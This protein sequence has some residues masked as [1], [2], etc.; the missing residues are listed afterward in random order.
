MFLAFTA[1]SEMVSKTRCGFSHPSWQAMPPQALLPKP[2][3]LLNS[4]VPR[5]RLWG[6][7]HV[8][9]RGLEPFWFPL[10]TAT[11]SQGEGPLQKQDSQ[12]QDS[13]KQGEGSSERSLL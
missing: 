6:D 2:G 1:A 9:G 5:P 11:P 8:W 4:H 12:K 10:P 7:G 3:L 13:Q